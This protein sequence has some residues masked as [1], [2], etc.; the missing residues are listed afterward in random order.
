MLHSQMRCPMLSL[1]QHLNTSSQPTR[2]SKRTCTAT[3]M[4]R[5]CLSFVSR[6]VR[7]SL[8]GRKRRLNWCVAHGV[9]E[10]VQLGWRCAPV[11]RRHFTH[12]MLTQVSKTLTHVSMTN[13]R[14]QN[15][16]S[17]H[18]SKV[19]RPLSRL[20]DNPQSTSTKQS[21]GGP[22]TSEPAF[23]TRNSRWFPMP[24]AA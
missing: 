3:Q 15:L 4:F 9:R 16:A 20:Y 8:A 7:L 18:V 21:S 23:L 14:I 22:S 11:G 6:A 10:W 13:Q 12:F 5:N 19:L 2:N 24:R 17:T 1:V